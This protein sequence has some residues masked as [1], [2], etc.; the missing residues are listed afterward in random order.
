MDKSRYRSLFL[1]EARRVLGNAEALLSEASSLR[2]NANTLMRAFH[3][4][5]GM[6][7]TMDYAGVTLL[8][9]ALEDVAQDIREGHLPPGP[10]ELAILVEGL[11]GLRRQAALIDAGEDPEPDV[12]LERRIHE[13]RKSGTTTAFRLLVPLGDDEATQEE[14]LPTPRTE[15]AAGAV[16]ELLS[17]CGQLRTVAHDANPGVVREV[18][19]LEQAA[20]A[21]YARLVEL[22][23]VPFGTAVPPLRRQLR[24]LSRQHGREATLETQGEDVLVDAELLAP[25]QAALIQLLHN[26]LI[27]GI[28]SPDERMER[29]KA[30][31]GRVHLRVEQSFG[32]LAVEFADD[33]R[34]L[35][36]EALRRAAGDADA[37]AVTLALQ[38][39]VSTA[40]KVDHHAGRGLGLSTVVH[41][42]ERLGGTVDLFSAP[43]RGL[44]LQIEVPLQSDLT[45]VLLVDAHR[46][47]LGLLRR[48]AQPVPGEHPAPPAILDLPIEGASVVRIRGLGDVRVDRVIGTVK[49][50]VRPAPWPLSRLPQLAA[51]AVGPDGR[52]LF[53]VD[54][55]GHAA[56]RT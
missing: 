12:E 26:A 25:L 36:V 42:I 3:T 4:L 56:G 38:A 32:T 53:V 54:P 45:E 44:R 31:V 28:E 43:G 9:H 40:A 11:D 48:H 7:A 6:G 18:E 33:G 23:Q 1:E 46:Q 41:G 39:G 47:T 8:A 27:H 14:P 5:K 55:A 52:I 35:D 30:R 50:L 24:I 37:D 13:H 51:T 20:Q 17:A 16:A 19:R 34:G 49:T 21:I 2:E 10:G 29:R 22:R 15:D